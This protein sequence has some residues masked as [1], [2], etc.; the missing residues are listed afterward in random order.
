MPERFYSTILLFDDKWAVF[1]LVFLAGTTV[2][3]CERGHGEKFFFVFSSNFSSKEERF[4]EN[5]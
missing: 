2:A 3:L 5:T 4:T 1:K